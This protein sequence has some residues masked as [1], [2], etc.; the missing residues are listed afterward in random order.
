MQRM[1][2]FFLSILRAKIL[3]EYNSNKMNE[4]VVFCLNNILLFY[5]Y[6]NDPSVV[7]HF[8]LIN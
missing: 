5:V 6:V 3:I 1:F 7:V 4:R 2:Y 8:I